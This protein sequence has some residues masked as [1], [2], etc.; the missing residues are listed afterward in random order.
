MKDLFIFSNMKVREHWYQNKQYV[1]KLSFIYITFWLLS[2]EGHLQ[3]GH[4][5]DRS[6][7]DRIH[8]DDPSVSGHRSAG[9]QKVHVAV[10]HLQRGHKPEQVPLQR[11][12]GPGAD[13][14]LSDVFAKDPRGL[15]QIPP[16]HK[17]EVI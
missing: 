16:D 11:E 4:L 1:I 14:N 3:G 12:W 2:P 13:E 15:W 7:A 17:S 8:A 9:D 6:D 10:E 5:G